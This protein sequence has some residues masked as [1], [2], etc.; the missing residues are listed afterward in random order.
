MR[1]LI[2]RTF[3]NIKGFTLVELLV[4]VAIIAILSVIGLTIFTGVQANA[5]DARRKTDIEAIANALEVARAP[6]SVYYTFL[7]ASGFSGGKV[8]LDSTTAQY[9]LRT[10]STGAVLDAVIANWAAT[11]ECEDTNWT[12]IPGGGIAAG[13]APFTTSV[14]ITHWKVCARLE[15]TENT[16]VFCKGSAQ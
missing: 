15:N 5:R 7:P 10:S 2:R 16:S 12:A 11:E 3:H 6:G 1:K 14:N 9:C 4:V 8:P 13:S